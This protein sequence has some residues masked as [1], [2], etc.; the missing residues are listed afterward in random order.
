MMYCRVFSSRF[1]AI[2]GALLGATLWAFLSPGARAQTSTASITGTV[3]DTGG[4]V[5]PAAAILLRNIATGVERRTA[6]NEIGN[7]AYL[8]IP[9]GDYTLEASK[10]GFGAQKLNPFVMVVNQ[11]ATFDFTLSVG[12]LAQ[13]VNVQAVAAQVEGS[14]AE[15]GAVVSEKAVADLPLNGRNFTQ[16]LTL[17]PGASPINVSQNSGG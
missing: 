2:P 4:A 14:T 10:S 5:I 6:S 13:T 9:P 3:R 16:L 11:T 8:N 7:Y 12:A 15:L 17:T 1:T